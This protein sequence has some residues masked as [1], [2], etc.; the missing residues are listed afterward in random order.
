VNKGIHG[1]RNPSISTNS[2]LNVSASSDEVEE[3]EQRTGLV[4]GDDD[5]EDEDM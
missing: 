4:F 2:D 3:E 1:I 5:S